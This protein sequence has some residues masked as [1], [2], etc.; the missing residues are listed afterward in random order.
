[1]KS[2]AIIAADN[3]TSHE[4][5]VKPF[6]DAIKANPNYQVEILDLPAGLLLARKK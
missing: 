4:E 5:K 2:G 6:V 3:I 1:M